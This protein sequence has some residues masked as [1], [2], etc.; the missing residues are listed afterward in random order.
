MEVETTVGRLRGAADS[1]VL[2]FLGVPYAA[3]PIDE[4]RWRPPAPPEPWAGIREASAF[5]ARAPQSAGDASD[6]SE[7]CLTLNVWTPAC[8]SSRRPVMVW[9]HG[10]AFV[11]GSSADVWYH[12]AP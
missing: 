10:G 4:R 7:D 12:G 3:P 9:I 8:D 6:W 2:G 11:S 5:G 1:G